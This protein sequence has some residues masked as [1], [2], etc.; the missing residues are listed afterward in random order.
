MTMLI[1]YGF[2][3]ARMNKQATAQVVQ[4]LRNGFHL[5]GQIPELES[6][7]SRPTTRNLDAGEG[8]ADG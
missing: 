8:L 5:L 2:A 6:A 1:Q 7:A 3:L 4:S